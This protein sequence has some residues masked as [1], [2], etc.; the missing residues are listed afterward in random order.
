MSTLIGQQH[1]QLH[2]AVSDELGAIGGD[3]GREGGMQAALGLVFLSQGLVSLGDP[4]VG[5]PL[6]RAQAQGVRLV[7]GLLVKLDAGRIAAHLVLDL[8]S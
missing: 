6:E 7:A 3:G 4:V 2:G 1:G 8:A 5:L